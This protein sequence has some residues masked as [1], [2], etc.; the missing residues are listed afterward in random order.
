MFALM[1]SAASLETTTLY[2]TLSCF[3]CNRRPPNRRRLSTQLNS[4]STASSVTEHNSAT[5]FVNAFFTSALLVKLFRSSSFIS[6][7]S[8][9]SDPE[10]IVCVSLSGCVVV[11]VVV[12]V[13]SFASFTPFVS[14][15]DDTCVLEESGSVVDAFPCVVDASGS[16]VDAFPSV[17][18]APV[19]VVVTA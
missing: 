11:V 14:L 12:S 7:T 9:T 6:P 18:D 2:P 4:I 13:V 5:D 8:A 17:V 19:V 3:A 1:P 15:I 10:T 16:V